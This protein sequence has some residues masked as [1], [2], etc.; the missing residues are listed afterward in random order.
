[1]VYHCFTNLGT[2][3]M[4][5]Y[6]IRPKKVITILVGLRVNNYPFK[7]RSCSLWIFD[8]YNCIDWI[9]VMERID[10]SMIIFT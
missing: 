3:V 7:G 2:M 10:F 4:F 6:V 1:M 8:T 5:L 9:L